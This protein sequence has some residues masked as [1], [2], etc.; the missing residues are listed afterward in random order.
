MCPFQSQSL[1][2]NINGTNVTMSMLDSN[3]G[4]IGIDLAN[5]NPTTLPAGTLSAKACADFNWVST[6]G[7][8]GSTANAAIAPYGHT[9][10]WISDLSGWHADTAGTQAYIV[11]DNNGA[12]SWIESIWVGA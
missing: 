2:Q 6:C 11:L 3:V 4:A 5:P 1:T 9:T 10:I 12:E 8:G 7:G